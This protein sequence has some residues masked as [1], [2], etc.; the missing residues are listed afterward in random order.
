MDHRQHH[1][2][3]SVTPLEELQIHAVFAA[4]EDL[5]DMQPGL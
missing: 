2:S 1:N 5:S 4:P 3:Y